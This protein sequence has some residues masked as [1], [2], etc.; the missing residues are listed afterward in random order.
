MCVCAGQRFA[1]L[2][3]KVVLSSVL[4]YF[5][6]VSDIPETD[7]QLMGELVLRP[8]GGNPIRLLPRAS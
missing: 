5:R 4:R 6:V 3:E 2:E 8:R 7:L 1:L